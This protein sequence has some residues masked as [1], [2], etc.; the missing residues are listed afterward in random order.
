LK[1]IHIQYFA[2]LRDLTKVDE[3]QRE[4]NAE[5]ALELY[6]EVRQVFGFDF[7]SINL[8]VAVNDS[9]SEWD[10]KLKDGDKLVFLPPV[11]GG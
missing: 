9:F 2:V 3:E 4:T 11:S 1:S 5:T 7:D 10:Y 8:R 6:E